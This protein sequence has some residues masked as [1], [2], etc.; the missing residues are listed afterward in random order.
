MEKSNIFDIATPPQ[1]E[2]FTFKEK[3]DSI[4]GTY[5]DKREGVDGFGND[6]I[7]YV[8]EDGEGKIWNVGI[9]KSNVV[10]TQ[11]M[12][13]ATLGRIVGFRFDDTK[14]AKKAG[15]NDTKIINAYHDEA[16]VNK[17]WLDKRK[18]MLGENGVESTYDSEKKAQDTFDSF[19]SSTTAEPLEPAVPETEETVDTKEDSKEPSGEK[20]EDD[21]VTSVRNLA[22]TQG[23]VTE[24]MSGEE[25]DKKIKEFTEMDYDEGNY[26]QMILKISN[27]KK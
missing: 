9:R 12:E 14:P 7:I 25:Q 20:Q 5:I 23:L 4:Q 19:P 13:T 3:G 10:T 18:K 21:M 6:Q 15:L 24:D 1:G 8:L 26:T 17:E 2:F 27:Y 16:V 22:I 11:Q